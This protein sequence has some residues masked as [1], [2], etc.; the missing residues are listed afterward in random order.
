MN[1]LGLGFIFRAKDET[2][3]V[4]EHLHGNLEN[5]KK[6]GESSSLS[7]TEAVGMSTTAI[8]GMGVAVG[9][10]A[11]GAAFELAEHADRMSL[12]ISQAGAAAHASADQIRELEEA[13][14][15]KGMDSLYFS[16]IA[17]AES[18][19]DL[20]KEGMGARE[21]VQALDGTMGLLRISMGALSS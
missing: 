2:R 5:L 17:A 10:V 6:V 14:R 1:A 21:A 3:E 7:I 15:Q 11:I 4:I 16:S 19:R 8:V 9:A 20:T 18:L 13:A 12:A